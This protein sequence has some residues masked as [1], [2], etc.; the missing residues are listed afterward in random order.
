MGWKKKLI[1]LA[2][3]GDLGWG[4]KEGIGH[5]HVYLQMSENWFLSRALHS[6]LQQ[7][8]LNVSSC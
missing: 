7:E 4:R 8:P 3:L 5:G 1:F 6:L 2:L